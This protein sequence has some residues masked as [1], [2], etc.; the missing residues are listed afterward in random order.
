MAINELYVNVLLISKSTKIIIFGI[1]L[2]QE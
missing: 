2:L 1:A